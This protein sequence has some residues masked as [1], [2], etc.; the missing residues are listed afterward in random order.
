[1]N[2]RLKSNC[3]DDTEAAGAE[4]AMRTREGDVIFLHGALGAGKTT[5]V[6]GFLRALGYDGPVVSPTY[7]LIEPYRAGNRDVA[8]LDLY[9]LRDGR[10][11]E[12]L[13]LRDL[14]D[15]RVIIVVEWPERGLDDLPAPTVSVE[16]AEQDDERV[17]AMDRHD[18]MDSHDFGRQ[19]GPV[20]HGL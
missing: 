14:L 11:L 1:V 2:L 5:L 4:L 10:E 7:T 19:A 6:R 16:I 12:N 15:G 18:E 13:G 8:H 20:R 9:R 3:E 17:I